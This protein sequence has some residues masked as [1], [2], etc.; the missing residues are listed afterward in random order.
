MLKENTLTKSDLKQLHSEYNQTYFDGKLSMPDFR[1]IAR[2]R[3]LGR[4]TKGKIPV[5]GI[6][7][8]RKDWSEGELKNTMIHEMIHQYVY[9]RMWGCRYSIIQHGLQF[10][11]VRWQLKRRFGLHIS[12]G[13]MF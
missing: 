5:I 2:K 6:S 10:H 4:F 13:P 9:E 7:A 1:F 8:Y 3:P 12:G 11:F